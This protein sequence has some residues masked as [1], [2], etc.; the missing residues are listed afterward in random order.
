MPPRSVHCIT[1]YV[2][3]MTVLRSWS[4]GTEVWCET[5]MKKFWEAARVR[6]YGGGASNVAFLED[7]SRLISLQATD[8]RLD[9]QAC[10]AGHSEG[11]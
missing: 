7:L 5:G 3:P 8:H 9:R 10:P 2:N 6:V 4:Q 11:H 1:R